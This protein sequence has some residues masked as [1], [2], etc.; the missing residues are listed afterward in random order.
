LFG[1]V[2]E[3]EVIVDDNVGGRFIWGDLEEPAMAG[4]GRK[5]GSN[6]DLVEAAKGQ[7]HNILVLYKLFED[8]RPVMLFDLQSQQIY[9]YPYAE[10]KATL[11][12][13]S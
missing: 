9:A 11:S 2:E 13:R 10:Y 3:E 4:A 1:E 6:D 7:L 8:K 5:K 12:E